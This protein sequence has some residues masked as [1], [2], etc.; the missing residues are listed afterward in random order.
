MIFKPE[1]VLFI[2]SL[3][4]SIC[5]KIHKFRFGQVTKNW[6]C[7]KRIIDD[8]YFLIVRDGRGV[9]TVS[10]E[11]ISLERGVV[12]FVPPGVEYSYQSDVKNPVNLI[13]IRC[14]IYR[15]DEHITKKIIK[16]KFW[17]CGKPY[18]FS[19][20][21]NNF[22]LFTQLNSNNNILAQNFFHTTVL[23]L[24]YSLLLDTEL[25]PENLSPRDLFSN[26]IENMKNNP[27]RRYH[28]PSLA[29]LSGLSEKYFI[30][31]FKQIFKITPK[32]MEIKLR[33]EKAYTLLSNGQKSI[34]EIA[35]LLGYSD[36]FIFSKQFK[37]FFKISPKY[38]KKW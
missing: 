38:A 5:F 31:K 18:N 37:K 15:G 12:I 25:K 2:N 17:Y 6:K 32:D 26:I 10:D 30:S 28:V 9:H 23:H 16:K 11:K 36:Q 13:V 35:S 3:L 14:G 4:P 21:E 19:A 22:A 1:F 34:R 7:E 20:V 33:M 27:E 24:L 29:R 8:L